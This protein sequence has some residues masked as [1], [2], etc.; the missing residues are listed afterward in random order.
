M[1]APR[2]P[3]RALDRVRLPADC[4]GHVGYVT[5]VRVSGPRERPRRL[6]TVVTPVGVMW[7]YSGDVRAA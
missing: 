2:R 4:G 3:I 1:S 5:H 7:V 6:L